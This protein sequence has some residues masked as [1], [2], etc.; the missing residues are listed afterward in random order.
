[1]N[2][3]SFI[4]LAGAMVAGPSAMAQCRGGGGGQG[5][6][7]SGGTLAMAATPALASASM[8]TGLG[9][10]SAYASQMVAQQRMML[11]MQQQQLREQKL[12]ARRYRAEETRAKVAESRAKTRAA[13][14]AK[15]GLKASEE[16][17]SPSPAQQPMRSQLAFQPVRR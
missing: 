2:R 3:W 9:S 11:A 17:A 15:Y 8:F 16:P 7:S 13:L 6:S 1:M 14:A 12:V 5:T 4:F 10:N